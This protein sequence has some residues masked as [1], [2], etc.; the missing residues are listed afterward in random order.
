MICANIEGRKT[1]IPFK[2]Y[3]VNKI[4]TKNYCHFTGKDVLVW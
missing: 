3:D 1:V 2:F 4:D